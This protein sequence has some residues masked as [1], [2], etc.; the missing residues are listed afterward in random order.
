MFKNKNAKKS[1]LR[2][3]TGC[4]VAFTL[5]CL[6]SPQ[7][8]KSGECETCVTIQIDTCQQGG[9]APPACEACRGLFQPCY[10][11]TCMYENK[12]CQGPAVGS[13]T[14]TVVGGI[15]GLTRVCVGGE[16]DWTNCLGQ[17]KC[18]SEIVNSIAG[19]RYTC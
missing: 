16:L 19:T 12:D 3:S 10:D 14:K 2:L 8:A 1:I 7:N 6:M 13:C 15:K 17:P 4:L 5:V 9:G 11:M 18:L